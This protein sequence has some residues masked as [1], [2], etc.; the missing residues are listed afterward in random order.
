MSSNDDQQHFERFMTQR[1]EV[2]RAYVSGDAEPL[3][4]IVTHE[5]PASFFDPQGDTVRGALEV[6]SK[7]DKDVAAFEAGGDS[8]LEIFHMAASN[9]VAY[10]VGMQRAQVRMVGKPDAVPFH[11]RVTEIFRREGDDWKLVHRHADAVVPKRLQ[12]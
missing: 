11:L 1:A 9:G 2:A 5:W 7:Y 8:D 12:H 6:A 10:W 3:D 4:H